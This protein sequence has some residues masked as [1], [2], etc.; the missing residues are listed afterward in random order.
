MGEREN[1]MVR[2][3]RERLPAQ[4]RPHVRKLIFYGSR[5]RDDGD[6][7]SDLDLVAIV[8]EK[9]PELENA[10][11]DAAYDVMWEFDFRPVISLKVFSQ[12][13]FQAAADKGFSFY[14]HV[15]EEGIAV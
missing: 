9:T 11:E 7:D 3:F 2:E 4:I 14:K 8:D 13:S 15:L 1:R 12:D 5:A 6:D 10:L